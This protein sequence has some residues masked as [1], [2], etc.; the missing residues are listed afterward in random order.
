MIVFHICFLPLR[1]SAFRMLFQVE[2]FCGAIATRVHLIEISPYFKGHLPDRSTLPRQPES[3]DQQVD[4]DI[5]LK[6]KLSA[7]LVS[8]MGAY[9]GLFSTIV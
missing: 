9:C 4:Q 7:Y 3:S 2:C 8:M 6:H 1:N 5:F